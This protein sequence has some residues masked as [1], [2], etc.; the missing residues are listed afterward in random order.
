MHP[1][2]RRLFSARLMSLP[3]RKCEFK[4]IV[5][6]GRPIDNAFWRC[7]TYTNSTIMR[8][9]ESVQ[10]VAFI[11]INI[12]PPCCRL[13]RAGCAPIDSYFSPL[14]IAQGNGVHLH[15]V[16]NWLLDKC[17]TSR[18][19]MAVLYE[20]IQ[21]RLLYRYKRYLSF[22][23]SPWKKMD[24]P[25]RLHIFNFSSDRTSRYFS[26]SLYNST[27]RAGLY[28]RTGV[29]G[30]MRCSS[31]FRVMHYRFSFGR[32]SSRPQSYRGMYFVKRRVV[33]W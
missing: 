13:S 26:F 31:A 12:A 21:Y 17:F 22:F 23:P 25:A 14:D 9:Y 24:T 16:V 5:S 19:E 8:R 28:E 32:R 15:V 30:E 1:I 4:T 20:A 18:P 29:S 7:Q 6:V 10:F 3:W 27:L 11:S 33:Q 2:V